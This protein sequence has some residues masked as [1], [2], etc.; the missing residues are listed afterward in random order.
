MEKAHSTNFRSTLE[1]KAKGLLEALPR[2]GLVAWM[3][4]L[5]GLDVLMLQL[6]STTMRERMN[7]KALFPRGYFTDG[8]DIHIGSWEYAVKRWYCSKRKRCV[9]CLESDSPSIPPWDHLTLCLR[10]QKQD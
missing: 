6:M 5:D 2:D 9:V 1:L 10:E 8:I 4:F 3:E 7:L